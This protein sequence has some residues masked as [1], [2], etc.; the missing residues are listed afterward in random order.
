MI[1]HIVNYTR[2]YKGVNQNQNSN[3]Q[4]PDRPQN[5]RPIACVIAQQYSS[6]SIPARK[7]SAYV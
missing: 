1:I 7:N 6:A 4:E 2:L 3:T 5:D